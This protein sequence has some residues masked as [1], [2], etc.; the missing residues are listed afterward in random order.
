MSGLFEDSK[1]RDN[2]LNLIVPLC[3]HADPNVAIVAL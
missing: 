1:I 3:I 2:M